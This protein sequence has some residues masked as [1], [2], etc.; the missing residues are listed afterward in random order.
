MLPFIQDRNADRAD[1]TDRHRYTVVLNELISDFNFD[2]SKLILVIKSFIQ[3]KF[4]SIYINDQTN[5]IG[6]YSS[7]PFQRPCH[8]FGNDTV[9]V[10]SNL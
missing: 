1:E 9:V 3:N 10:E 2:K 7:D 4:M 5:T 8:L 6:T